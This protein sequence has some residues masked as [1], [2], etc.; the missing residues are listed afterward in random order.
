MSLVAEHLVSSNSAN[1]LC[2]K[3]RHRL[4]RCCRHACPRCQ[5]GGT[6][7]EK[8]YTVALLANLADHVSEPGKGVIT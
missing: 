5:G 4:L 3:T 6:N 8:H 1:H 7:H 2:H